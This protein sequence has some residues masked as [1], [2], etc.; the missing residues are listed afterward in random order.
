MNLCVARP[1]SV[2]SVFCLPC[3]G[4]GANFERCAC[5]MAQARSRAQKQCVRE[6][7]RCALWC[8]EKRT[9][10]LHLHNDKHYRENMLRVVVVS[11]CLLIG[12]LASWPQCNRLEFDHDGITLMYSTTEDLQQYTFK[13]GYYGKKG[14]R[15]GFV[16]QQ[17]QQQQAFF[18]G[19]F[20]HNRCSFHIY[21]RPTTSTP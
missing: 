15:K 14:P 16:I 6:S 9:N 3:G 1:A 19:A 21:R 18:V 11:V 7:S 4:I 20:V 10:F 5:E 8:S 13:Y 12:V 17:Q 2:W